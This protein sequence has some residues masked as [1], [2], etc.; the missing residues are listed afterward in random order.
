M[1]TRVN[2]SLVAKVTIGPSFLGWSLY[3]WETIVVPA[4]QVPWYRIVHPVFGCTH[5]QFSVYEW[6]LVF[7]DKN[8]LVT[9]SHCIFAVWFLLKLYVTATLITMNQLPWMGVQ[10]YVCYICEKCLCQ[11]G[12]PF[13][14]KCSFKFIWVFPYTFYMYTL[15]ESVL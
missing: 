8:V 1:A 10:L 2:F 15:W 11:S 7:Q 3:M 9:L 5:P 14:N 4:S 13:L 12:K 6:A